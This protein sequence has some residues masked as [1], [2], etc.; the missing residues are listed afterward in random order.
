MKSG[1]VVTALGCYTGNF[2]K[3]SQ[4]LRNLATLKMEKKKEDLLRT[5]LQA[6]SNDDIVVGGN[7]PDSRWQIRCDEIRKVSFS[8]THLLNYCMDP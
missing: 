5:K 3:V 2:F 4:S 7:P 6:E 8:I 1:Q